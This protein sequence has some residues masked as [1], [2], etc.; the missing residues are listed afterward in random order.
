MGNQWAQFTKY[1]RGRT[2]NSIKNHW[3]SIMKKRASQYLVRFF[4]GN[5]GIK[6]LKKI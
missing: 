5:L 1:L 4:L 6:E 3:N 2:D